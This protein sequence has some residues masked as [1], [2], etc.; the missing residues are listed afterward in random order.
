MA[1]NLVV[2]ES[3]AK[4]KT[5][6]KY[7]GREFTVISSM[8]HV[9]DLP[10][11]KLGVDLEKDFAPQYVTIPGKTK[12]LAK[13]KEEA[14]KAEK[15]Y[16]ATDPDREGE[17]IAWHIASQLKD[18]ARKIKRVLFY[19]ITKESVKS[20]IAHPL[21]IDQR[22]FE[23]QQARRILDRIVGYQVSPFLW[24]T[25]HRGLSA[26]RVQTV[27]LRLICEREQEI[28]KFVPQEYWSV[29]ARLQGRENGP[30]E[31]LLAKID[32]KKIN[33]KSQAEVD[34]LAAQLRT[35]EFAVAKIDIKDK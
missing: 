31:A 6:N 10:G 9:R 19:E 3:P 16:L 17:A 23:A 11:S 24:K 20:G 28:Q 7:L 22:K 29:G 2:V 33:I 25:V 12:V 21:K 18:G 35:A 13:I 5:I 4:A 15:V 34:G 14:A 1:K 30:F 32:D 27:A 26:G 8:G